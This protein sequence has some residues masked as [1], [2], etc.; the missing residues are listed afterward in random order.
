MYI[1]TYRLQGW[2]LGLFLTVTS[3][4]VWLGIY[5]DSLKLSDAEK[6]PSVFT[7]V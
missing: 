6:P 2:V 5:I 7:N 4:K 3:V 1:V